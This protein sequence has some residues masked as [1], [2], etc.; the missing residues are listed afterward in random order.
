MKDFNEQR[1]IILYRAYV[2][3]YLFNDI[4]TNMNNPLVSYD[5]FVKQLK[6]I[7][8]SVIIKKNIKN[9]GFL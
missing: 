6:K 9:R 2:L 8:K 1:K 5:V 4:D 3:D 7:E